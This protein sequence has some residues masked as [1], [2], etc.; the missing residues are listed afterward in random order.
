[1]ISMTMGETVTQQVRFI[2]LSYLW[3]AIIDRIK[4]EPIYTI[5]S[6]GST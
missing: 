2:R 3:L 5:Q 1:M 4:R 6:T